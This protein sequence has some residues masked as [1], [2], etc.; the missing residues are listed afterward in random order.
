MPS[1]LNSSLTG[2]TRSPSDAETNF[3]RASIALSTGAESLAEIAQQTLKRD[4][5]NIRPD[6]ARIILVEGG[7]SILPSFGGDLP[8]RGYVA[9]R[10][11]E[12][13]RKHGVP[14]VENKPLAQVLYRTVEVGKEVPENLYQAV[15]E[16]LAYVYRL[17][18]GRA[19]AAGA[20]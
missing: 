4:F 19:A 7:P 16:V 17:R 18:N 20:A 6:E 2:I 10:I 5:R 9:L 14:L 15:A 11:R 3:T 13:A 12:E 8:R 1:S